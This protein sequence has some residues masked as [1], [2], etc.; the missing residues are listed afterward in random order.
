M[1]GVILLAMNLGG[2]LIE[3]SEDVRLGDLEAG[4][5]HNSCFRYYI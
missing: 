5:V 3:K 2:M 1:T 4:S